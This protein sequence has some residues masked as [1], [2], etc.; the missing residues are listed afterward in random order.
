M[1]TSDHKPDP[2]AKGP[3]MLHEADVG[4]GERTP[5]QHE[6]DQMIREIPPRGSQQE[7][8]QAASQQTGQQSG[9]GNAA[10]P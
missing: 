4:S 2:G 9:Q 3:G 7:A 6:T 8:G 10:K 1:R 5:A